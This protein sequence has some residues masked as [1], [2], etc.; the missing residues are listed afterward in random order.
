MAGEIV[1]DR[2][3]TRVDRSVSTGP[4]P[5]YVISLDV[6]PRSGAVIDD[7]KVT[8]PPRRSSRR[9]REHPVEK[10]D[11]DDRPASTTSSCVAP[12]AY[13]NPEALLENTR[14]ETTIAGHIFRTQRPRSSSS[15][16]G[17][18]FTSP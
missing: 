4:R 18:A 5:E 13:F 9:A 8:G 14:V 17:A 16:A 7:S 6:L 10:M 2:R 12:R 11:D 15:P 3:A 1:S